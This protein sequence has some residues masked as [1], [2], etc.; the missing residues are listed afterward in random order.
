M[1]KALLLPI[2]LIIG[3]SSAFSQSVDSYLDNYLGKNKDGY[4]QPVADILTGVFHAGLISSPRID[5]SFYFNFGIVASVGFVTNNLKKFKATTEAPFEPEQTIEAS[6]IIGAGAPQVVT[7]L[8]GTSFVFPGGIGLAYAPFGLPQLT[9]GGILHSELNL[10]FL[11]YDFGGDIGNFQ[12][13]GIALRH[14][15]GHYLKLNNFYLNAGYAFQS[16]KV[17]Q[18]L[19][20]QTHLISIDGGQHY[21]HFYYYGRLGYQ[22]G[23]MD[24]NY[25]EYTEQCDL[26]V[27][28]SNTN[29]FPIFVG[30]GGGVDIGKF[31]RL[32]LGASYANLPIG[33][34]GI[35]FRF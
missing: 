34:A 7:G 32:N 22:L 10:R 33:E 18:R 17:G 30:L 28:I 35:I 29:S 6:T 11:A 2:L 24:A 1:K 15:I 20:I 23:N 4:V 14:D 9:F 13:I 5:S 3:F 21:K 27:K 31:L 8:N 16:T 25:T 12:L 19:N 26:K